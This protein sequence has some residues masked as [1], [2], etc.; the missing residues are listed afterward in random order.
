MGVLREYLDGQFTSDS[1]SEVGIGGFIT[2]ARVLDKTEMTREIPTAFV[3]D[4]SAVNDHIIRN[5]KKITI[6]GAVSDVFR[7]PSPLLQAVRDAQTQVGVISQ[8]LPARTQS[9]LARVSGVVADVQTQVDRID[10]LIDGAR[11][12]AGFFGYTGEEGKTNTERFVDFIE[13]LYAS[14][15]LIPID[16][17][18]RTYKNMALTS[19][20]IVRDNTTNSLTFTLD[21]TEFRVAQTIFVG[22]PARNPAPA[23]GGQAESETDK[24]TQEGEEVPQSLADSILER[25]GL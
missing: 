23:T 11:G 17:P 24:G 12:V 21:A 6:E 1:L 3:E 9:Q 13:G 10:G 14:Q 19:V 7:R 16:A 25:F 8:F 2:A 5:P 18:F 22:G 4:G 15:A 20:Q